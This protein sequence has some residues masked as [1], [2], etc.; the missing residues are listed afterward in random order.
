MSNSQL[1]RD[2]MM[3]MSQEFVSDL[4]DGEIKLNQEIDDLLNG[5]DFQQSM[6][7][8]KSPNY[9]PSTFPEENG[10]FTIQQSF[11]QSQSQQNCISSTYP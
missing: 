10:T 8:E 5:I 4:N 9:I 3:P 6:S 1:A 11:L 2:M 7:Q